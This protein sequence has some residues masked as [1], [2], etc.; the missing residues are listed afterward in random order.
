MLKDNPKNYTKKGHAHSCN[1]NEC[2]LRKTCFR[3]TYNSSKA[4]N[5]EEKDHNKPICINYIEFKL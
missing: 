4:L 5:W 3:A 1:N 2:K